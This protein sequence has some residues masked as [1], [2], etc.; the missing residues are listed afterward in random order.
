MA[1][2]RLI[3]SWC[4]TNTARIL[5]G[6]Y[7]QEAHEILYVSVSLGMFLKLKWAGIALDLIIRLHRP[8]FLG[9]LWF[10]LFPLQ[11]PDAAVQNER[12]ASNPLS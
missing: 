5:R 9:L 3:C 10:P 6:A 2:L 1:I 8:T 7:P 11:P 4:F 12:E